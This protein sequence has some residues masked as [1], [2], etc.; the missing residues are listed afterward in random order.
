MAY[1]FGLVLATNFV[2]LMFFEP[3]SLA[4]LRG[5][6]A[7]AWTGVLVLAVVCTAMGTVLW[8]YA[9]TRLDVGQAVI[10]VY[11][12]PFF[13]VLL[14]AVFLHERITPSMIAGGA[15]TLVGTILVVS[16]DS[17]P[18]KAPEPQKESLT[19]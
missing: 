17:T 8:L 12:L 9:L 10:S 4:A 1:G 14:S 13:G 11:L 18:A 6:S 16:T 7:S 19:V 5:Y 2:L 3:L 15:I